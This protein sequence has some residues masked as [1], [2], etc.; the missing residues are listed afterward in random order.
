MLHNLGMVAHACDP[1][2]MG[3]RGRRIAVEGHPWAK[4]QR[5]SLKNN[6]SIKG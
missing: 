3:N 1:S 2:H 5:R 6:Y 4:N